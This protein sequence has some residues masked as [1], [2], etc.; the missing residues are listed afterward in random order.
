MRTFVH[1]IE[2][3]L[4][5]DAKKAPRGAALVSSRAWKKHSAGGRV[6]LLGQLGGKHPA[7]HLL[8]RRG[9]GA[10]HGM[11]LAGKNPNRTAAN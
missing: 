6:L 7:A 3:K 4:L 1:P 9:P 11:A 10:A 8:G 5:G 2:R